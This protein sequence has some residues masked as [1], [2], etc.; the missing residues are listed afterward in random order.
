MD[1]DKLLSSRD[2]DMKKLV[3]DTN[4]LLKRQ[5]QILEDHMKDTNEK[6][7]KIE[8]EQAMIK[9]EFEDKLSKIKISGGD[10]GLKLL[11]EKLQKNTEE[12]SKKVSEMEVKM[13][14]PRSFGGGGGCFKG[15]RPASGNAAK[16]SKSSDD[17]QYVPRE[18]EVIDEELQGRPNVIHIV[19]FPWT[20]T[21]SGLEEEATKVIESL[22]PSGT[23]F[24]VKARGGTRSGS[25][26]FD[27]KSA[28]ET[29]YEKFKLTGATVIDEDDGKS[30]DVYLKLDTPWHIRKMG[31][32]LS[33]LWKLTSELAKEKEICLPAG[34][35]VT[36]FCK[37]SLF[38]KK[39][40]KLLE[41]FVI[42]EVGGKGS[43]T[44]Q[45]IQNITDCSVAP[46]WI[47]QSDIDRLVKAAN[48]SLNE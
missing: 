10:A 35:L 8:K 20:L 31:K 18:Q 43:K 34:I 23:H 27:S 4:D 32:A 29:V 41:L 17:G 37:R 7:A 47:Q 5:S 48:A 3:G 24:T 16:R 2:N 11:L 21:R 26:F 22:C 33:V 25:A 30:H 13:N 6:F 14:A 39:G 12:T 36:G 40:R 42:G 44:Y 15:S 9:K 38:L 1:T 28:A 46:S 19:K 45:V